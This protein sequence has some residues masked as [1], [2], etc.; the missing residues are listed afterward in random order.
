MSAQLDQ[1][2]MPPERIGSVMVFRTFDNVSYGLI[3]MN[4]KPVFVGDYLRAPDAN[5]SA[6]SLSLPDDTYIGSGSIK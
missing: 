4:A 5:L 1:V 6:D 2:R 3:M